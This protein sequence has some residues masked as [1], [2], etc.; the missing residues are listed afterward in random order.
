M[1]DQAEK[2]VLELATAESSFNYNVNINRH[3]K[4]WIF[5]GNTHL[6]ARANVDIKT[7]FDLTNNFAITA[8]HIEKVLSIS[9]PKPMVLSKNISYDF[10]DVEKSFLIG[11]SSEGIYNELQYKANQQL[12]YLDLSSA[13]NKSKENASIA[14]ENIFTPL[15]SMNN[16]GYK[17]EVIYDY[18]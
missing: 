11:P 14:L 16:M 7:G 2:T 3:R 12:E 6:S 10:G 8:N 1:T 17:V 13:Y 5:D 18:E 15:I 4:V 9:L